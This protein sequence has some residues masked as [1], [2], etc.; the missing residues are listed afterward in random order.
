MKIRQRK[1]A[2]RSYLG[3]HDE[4]PWRLRRREEDEEGEERGKTSGGVIQALMAQ[5][6]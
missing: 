5:E 4:N 1:A 6:Q 2:E 3:R